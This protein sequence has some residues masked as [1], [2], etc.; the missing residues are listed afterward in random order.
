VAERPHQPL[1]GGLRILLVEDHDDSRLVFQM[2]LQQ[3]GHLVEAAATAEQALQLAGCH[4][5]DL[6]IS[7]LGLPDLDGA[8]LM[9]I[10]RDRCSLRGIAVTGF[11]MDEDVRRS[12][13]ACFDYHLTKPIDPAKVDQLLASII[14]RMCPDATAGEGAQCTAWS[15]KLSKS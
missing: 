2:V 3:K 10:L 13:F 12:K 8:E 11:A 4:E 9:T 14:K 5:F 1:V 6:V 15:T 7:D